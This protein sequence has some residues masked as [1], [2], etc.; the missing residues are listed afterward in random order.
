VG[1][2]IGLEEVVSV[3]VLLILVRSGEQMSNSYQRNL[4]SGFLLRDYEIADE[5]LEVVDFFSFRHRGAPVLQTA[6]H[7]WLDHAPP[8]GYMD[9]K[10]ISL[11][12][13]V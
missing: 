6:R 5:T 8:A 4:I 3:L 10:V 7:D 1:G 13:T 11:E 12:S 2:H 9:A